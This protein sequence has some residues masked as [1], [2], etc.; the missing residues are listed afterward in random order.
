[1]DIV[2]VDGDAKDS[3]RIMEDQLMIRRPRSGSDLT[4][5]NIID[6]LIVTKVIELSF[7]LAHYP[8]AR[9]HI[10]AIEFRQIN[11]PRSVVANS[12]SLQNLAQQND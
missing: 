5:P 4:S 1:L 8:R 10:Y 7:S 9:R 12:V 11:S 6:S 2:E 3:L